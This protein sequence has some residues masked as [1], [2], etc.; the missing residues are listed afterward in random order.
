MSETHGLG[1]TEA[2][3]RFNSPSLVLDQRPSVVTPASCGMTVSAHSE[4]GTGCGFEVV[5]EREPASLDRLCAYAV[6][7]IRIGQSFQSGRTLLCN[8]STSNLYSA[9][10]QNFN[11]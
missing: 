2:I 8:T 9:V 3:F 6:R 4:S 1:D 5:K 7:W 10:I 11:S